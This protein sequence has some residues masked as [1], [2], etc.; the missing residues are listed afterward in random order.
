MLSPVSLSP[1]DP[2]LGCPACKIH[3]AMTGSPLPPPAD[4]GFLRWPAASCLQIVQLLTC[5]TVRGRS[6]LG[7]IVSVCVS[8]WLLATSNVIVEPDLTCSVPGEKWRPR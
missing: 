2:L 8:P 7:A 3:C 6:D 4:P 1:A 5:A